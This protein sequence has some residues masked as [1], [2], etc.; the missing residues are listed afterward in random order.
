VIER[1]KRSLGL[2]LSR[3][4][5]QPISKQFDPAST[6][7][8]DFSSL[9]INP[10]YYKL[11]Y[12]EFDRS[13]KGKEYYKS[14]LKLY[15]DQKYSEAKAAFDQA[16]SLGYNEFVVLDSRCAAMNKMGGAWQKS[17]YEQSRQLCEKY[18]K[19]SYKVR[20][21]ILAD[22]SLGIGRLT[23]CEGWECINKL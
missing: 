8:N 7:A 17:A 2:N 14:G 21:E 23:S 12:V 1:S 4:Y 3:E 5:S 20:N 11:H 15:G 22:H 9:R 16:I 6:N 19:T 10:L 18:G 13:R